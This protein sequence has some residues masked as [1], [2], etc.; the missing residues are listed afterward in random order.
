MT[1]KKLSDALA[2]AGH[3]IT[4]ETVRKD[5]SKGAPRDS[6]EAYLRWREKHAEKSA[7]GD[8]DLKAARLK[9]VLEQTELTRIR[10]EA[11]EIELG[12]ARGELWRK[13]EVLAAYKSTLAKVRAQLDAKLR[14]DLPARCAGQPAEVIEAAIG[15]VLDAAYAAI[16]QP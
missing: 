14:V 13:A 11:E 4:P 8:P 9:L 12:Q 10:K 3:K 6:A 16:S 7:R 1:S 2:S 5:W 15:E